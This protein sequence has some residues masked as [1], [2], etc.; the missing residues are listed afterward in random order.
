MAGWVELGCHDLV[1]SVYGASANLILLDEVWGVSPDDY[2]EGLRPTQVA[3][4]QPQLWA[5]STA[6]R[7]ATSLMPELMAPARAGQGRVMLADW[8][9][10]RVRM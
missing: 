9:A 10:R 7:R 1:Q 2:R 5:L 6:H 3:R 8:G 4:V